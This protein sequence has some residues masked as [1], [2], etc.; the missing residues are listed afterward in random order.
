[1]FPDRASENAHPWGDQV[2]PYEELGGE[3]VLH[4][5]VERFYELMDETSPGLRAMHPA[6]DSNSRRNLF[7]FLS[8]WIGGP[9]LYMERKGHPML[10]MR[11]APFAIGSEEAVE[12]MRCM[13]GALD[14][15]GVAQPLRGYLETRLDQTAHHVRNTDLG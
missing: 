2:T 15:V 11:H 3:P 7:E 9:N 10:R 1:M 8:G 6:D 14:D 12:W 13:R 5:L 4:E